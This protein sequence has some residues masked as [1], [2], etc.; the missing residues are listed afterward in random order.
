MLLVV[1]PAAADEI[2]QAPS[3]NM[4]V[5]GSMTEVIF[6]E[7][8]VTSLLLRSRLPSLSGVSGCRQGQLSGV[9]GC[10]FR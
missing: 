9:S 6:R 10:S 2:A 1:S 5:Y 7:R 4:L 8:T 3:V